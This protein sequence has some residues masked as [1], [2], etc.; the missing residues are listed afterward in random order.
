MERVSFVLLRRV[1]ALCIDL[2]AGDILVVF[3]SF[4]V[5]MKGLFLLE[6]EDKAVESQID[7]FLFLFF[8]S[9]FIFLFVGFSVICKSWCLVVTKLN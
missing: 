4:S 7:C 3:C 2:I 6:K 5:I 8:F 9:F 1:E